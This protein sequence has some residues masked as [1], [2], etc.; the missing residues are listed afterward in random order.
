MSDKRQLYPGPGAETVS[1]RKKASIIKERATTPQHKGRMDEDANPNPC[2][3]ALNSTER[4]ILWCLVDG[5]KSGTEIRLVMEAS[6]ADPASQSPIY[7]NADN[8]Q[9]KGYIEVERDGTHNQ[10]QLTPKGK[11]ALEK[12]ET[13]IQKRKTAAY[14]GLGGEGEGIE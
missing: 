3:S 4:D 6:L 7:D 10:Y 11:Q 12:W 5:P 8:L 9:E 2:L 14:T 13:F 1:D